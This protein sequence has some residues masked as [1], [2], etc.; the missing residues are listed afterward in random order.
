[1]CG[2][3][4]FQLRWLSEW[5]IRRI[6]AAQTVKDRLEMDEEGPAAACL[7]CFSV[8]ELRQRAICKILLDMHDTRSEHPGRF[9]K[10]SW[11]G[12]CRSPAPLRSGHFEV[13]G[14]TTRDDRAN[15]AP[16]RLSFSN[17]LR[18]P[19]PESTHS[20]WLGRQDENKFAVASLSSTQESL[21]I[22]YS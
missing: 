18:L 22:R 16:A 5:S 14:E 20:G 15:D 1:M 3:G 12:K 7:S 4:R 8:S 6:H 17:G 21:Q 13:I 2:I 10:I 19:A 9:T 11:T